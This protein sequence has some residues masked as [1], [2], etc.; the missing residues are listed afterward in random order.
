[1]LSRKLDGIRVISIIEDGD[2]KFYSRAGNEFTSLGKVR[3]ALQPLADQLNGKV[4][5]GELC[6]IDDSG[7]EDFKAAVSQIKRKDYT[8]ENPRYKIFDMLPLNDFTLKE[9]STKLSKRLEGIRQIIP[10][11]SKVLNVLEQVPLTEQTFI[12]HQDSVKEFGWE[13]LMLRLDGPYKG[14]RSNDLLKVKPFFDAEFVI[15]D[16]EMGRKPM[17]N[18]SGL[19]VEVDCLAAAKVRYKGNIISVGSG[20][21][22]EQRLHFYEHPEEL[23]GRT[24]TVKYFEECC[25]KDGKVSLRFPTMNHLWDG[26]RNI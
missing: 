5:D 25:D 9:C 2:I 10:P 19:M 17:K 24:I 13:G 20:W 14:K 23:I 22:D 1:M 15:E 7:A 3:E 21:S 16:V 4:L 8:I 26:K 11:D 12:E 18:D 6:I